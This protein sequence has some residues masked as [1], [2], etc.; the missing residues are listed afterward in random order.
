MDNDKKGWV[1][2][3]IVESPTKERTIS[4][5]LKKDF[6][7]KSSF[8]H[9][10]DLPL[11]NLGI[12]IDENFSP[13]YVLVGRA[14]KTITSLKEA[15]KKSE[16]VYL[17]TDYD[18]EGEAIAWH[19]TQVLAVSDS[20]V[21]RV[22]FHEI[23]PEAIKDALKNP[24]G[25]DMNLVNS[26]QARRILDR[27]VGYK[28]SPLL[29]R[30]IARGLSAGRVQSVAVRL[31]VE[32]ENEIMN[33]H[34]VEY[35][36]V[37]VRLSKDGEEFNAEVISRSGEKIEKETVHH[38]FADRYKV[39][40]TTINADIAKA[41]SEELKTLTYVVKSVESKETSR[42]PAPPF[43]TSS[44]QQE[45]V[46]KTGFSASKTMKLAQELYEGINIAEG[47][48]GLIT[49]HRTD[50]VS[51]ASIAQDEAEKYIKEK[52]GTEYYPL[53]RRFFRTKT[54]GAQEAHE[55][56]RPTSIMREPDIMKKYLTLDQYK[57]YKLI[58]QRF[59]ASQM[60]D[61]KY[62]TMMVE[63]TAG[64]YLLKA[65][66]RALKFS[67]YLRIY[68]DKEQEENNSEMSSTEDSSK[69]MLPVMQAG[70]NLNFVE[71]IPQQHFTEPP[72]RYNEASL[73]KT[74][75][76][77]G[78]GRP[79]T[80]APTVSTILKRKYV[81]I[82]ERKFYPTELG[83]KTTKLL[84]EYFSDIV[85]INFTADIEEK[86]DVV[87]EGGNNWQELVKSF[88]EPFSEKLSIAD[89]TIAGKPV[90]ELTDRKCP[91]CGAPMYLRESRYGRFY[92]CSR[93]PQC[94][95]KANV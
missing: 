47:S 22:T 93:W 85:D 3:M 69:K 67:G 39:K 55:C 82:N 19:L 29:W 43:T 40:T 34:K 18:R 36:T 27:L 75:E 41:M 72:P 1:N 44:M 87:A 60:A 50:S 37:A 16:N 38:L 74:L 49:Y 70:D 4:K 11:N 95:G 81:L 88:Y 57:L 59:V 51:V 32:R 54:K 64:D 25:I 46:R 86:L 58:W 53:Q 63:I 89:K 21:K 7:V 9:I 91:V 84:I 73:I 23:T 56:I 15:A 92:S 94:K 90:P 28:L 33:F 71:A 62:D 42:S 30:K 80:Y 78:I 26:Q 31:I 14:K 83:E 17:A 65:T 68:Q 77:N 6:I 12:K 79:S 8:G 61:A 2:L 5:Y 35:W 45:G 20:K 24:R 52:I 66:G 10:R 13:T 48:V 76:K